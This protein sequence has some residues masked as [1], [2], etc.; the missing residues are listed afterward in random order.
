MTL[1]LLIFML[2]GLVSSQLMAT[3]FEVKVSTTKDHLDSMQ[4]WLS[5]LNDNVAWQ[6]R[7]TDLSLSLD[8]QEKAS[9]L[10][11][12][13]ILKLGTASDQFPQSKLSRSG[14]LEI[15]PLYTL[16]QQEKLTLVLR[17]TLSEAH[18]VG[19]EFRKI[20]LA[21]T[22]LAEWISLP[23]Q[24]VDVAAIAELAQAEIAVN[25][26]LS[27]LEKHGQLDVWLWRLWNSGDRQALEHA[28]V[29][30]KRTHPDY[31][32]PG[33]LL[34]WRQ[35]PAITS[36]QM[37][38]INAIEEQNDDQ[39]LSLYASHPKSFNCRFIQSLWGLA[40][41]TARHSGADKSYPNF[42]HIV[43]TCQSA[44]Q[45]ID[46]LY[47]A[48]SLLSPEQIW[49]LVEVER[50]HTR[51][52]KQERRF[53]QFLS[54]L[55][56]ESL[57]QALDLEDMPTALEFIRAMAPRVI[58][59]KDVI[60]ASQFAWIYFNM[61][62]YGHAEIWFQRVLKWQPQNQS[63]AEGHL[64][65]LLYQERFDEALDWIAE[66]QS[67][68]TD[69]EE[70]IRDVYLRAAWAA[71]G[72][73]QFD[74]V[75]RLLANC[76]SCSEDQIEEQ[77]LQALLL[78][79]K[80]ENSLAAFAKLYRMAPTEKIANSYAAALE[81]AE[82]WALLAELSARDNGPFT[83]AYHRH[84]AAL[85]YADGLLL[86]K[87]E[88][89]PDFPVSTDDYSSPWALGGL[90]GRLRR[91]DR[92]LD[93]LNLHWQPHL[94]ARLTHE[95]QELR[96]WVNRIDMRTK[97]PDREFPFGHY[98]VS[99][100]TSTAE[101]TIDEGFVPGLLWSY[102]GQNFWQLFVSRTPSEGVRSPEWI[103]RIRWQS[104]LEAIG[105]RL[106]IEL[107]R[108]SV[109]DSVLSYVGMQ[110]IYTGL[111]WGQV[112]RQ[113]IEFQ[114]TSS[115]LHHP[116]SV[117]LD[118]ETLTG[119]DV[120]KNKHWQLTMVQG[121]DRTQ[122]N[123]SHRVFGPILQ[124]E[125]Y[126]ENLNYFTWGHG[127]YYSPQIRVALG[128]FGDWLSQQGEDWLAHLKADLSLAYSEQDSAPCY[129]ITPKVVAANRCLFEYS[130]DTSFGPAG[131]L[132]AHAARQLSPHWQVGVGARYALA[133][134]WE[135]LSYHL[136]LRFFVEPRYH[137]YQPDLEEFLFNRL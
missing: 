75:D 84:L 12:A 98:L 55:Q 1:R 20:V 103:A 79:K 10:T 76:A 131:T 102:E 111:S 120:Q 11:S 133:D 40:A 4:N 59:E 89:D 97:K 18:P 94:Q 90:S 34:K 8:S 126:D 57:Q 117:V 47:K 60:A 114:Y 101:H 17:V 125:Q 50:A 61:K 30:L 70:L 54:E 42:L 64:L 69:S 96:L 24:T 39:L 110:D 122:D 124:L 106:G 93:Y 109:R 71:L 27:E 9:E 21:D 123:E 77:H 32:P 118:L 45:R 16:I 35:Q 108:D 95:R 137:V 127:G 130:A 49:S 56:R 105:G 15:Q 136:F 26:Y 43:L 37:A 104:R 100:P 22:K 115:G 48:K 128:I 135:E 113:G 52:L 36:I 116:I 3:T 121:F 33:E 107:Y 23:A 82:Q 85:A 74:K 80:G 41:A 2:I 31:S 119:D 134:E 99:A 58:A 19:V 67:W 92:D 129:A 65:I 132:E 68:L 78:Y 83:K 62:A 38:I 25:S 112:L 53:Q 46:T 72:E 86:L 28:L 91:G 6:R 87:N 63:A 29:G 44:S 5:E 81:S 73:N 88:Y 7:G 13:L 14:V 51:N 66:R